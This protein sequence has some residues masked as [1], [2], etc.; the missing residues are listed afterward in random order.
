MANENDSRS[1]G[2]S[3]AAFPLQ[4]P[5]DPV[6]LT[7]PA[8]YVP[9]F[10][11]GHLRTVE[12]SGNWVEQQADEARRALEKDAEFDPF[13]CLTGPRNSV[14][15]DLDVL[16]QLG[17]GPVTSPLTIEGEPNDL[18]HALEDVAR[19]VC[20]DLD[21]TEMVGESVTEEDMTENHKVTTYFAAA[22]WAVA[23]AERLLRDVIV[24]EH[25]R[26]KAALDAADQSR[27][28]KS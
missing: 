20:K 25:N 24:P 8:E 10:R 4:A 13:D 11:L 12:F 18:K 19:Y 15:N 17:S 22:G 26:R 27:E 3:L 16:R 1:A 28:V 7:I 5:H 14:V 6:P 9:V 2:L 23:E 21:A